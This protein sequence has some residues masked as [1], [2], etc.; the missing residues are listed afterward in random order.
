MFNKKYK[1]GMKDAAKA[2]EAFGEKQEK[3]L[4]VILEELRSGNI[5]IKTAIDNLDGNINSLYEY[6]NSQELAKLYTVYTPFDIK[7]LKDNEKLFLGGA[8]LKLTMDRTPTDAQQ[9]YLNAVLKYLSLKEPPFGVDLFAIENI[10]EINAQKAIYQTVLEYLILQDGNHY[11]ETEVQQEFLDSFCLNLRSR[12]TI[13]KHVEILYSSTGSTGLSEKYNVAD[14]EIAIK[15]RVA[16]EREKLLNT[17]KKLDNINLQLVLECIYE[18]YDEDLDVTCGEYSSKSSC[19]K[20][21]EGELRKKHNSI[22]EAFNTFSSNS[23]DKKALEE[24]KEEVEPIFEEIRHHSQNLQNIIKDDSF[25]EIIDL[26]KFEFYQESIQ[27]A[28]KRNL[29]DR[30]CSI[31]SFEYYSKMLEYES[32]DFGDGFWSSSSWDCTNFFEVDIYEDAQTSADV[33]AKYANSIVREKVSS[34]IKNKIEEIIVKVF[35]DI[36]LHKPQRVKVK[37]TSIRK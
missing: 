15:E 31:P 17:V 6:L 1:K 32:D 23:L 10:E 35:P 37:T 24:I 30:L 34:K 5:D 22:C 26:L 21:F 2:Y 28:L 14:P 16:E 36:D 7:H 4:E 9:I 3:A 20:A 18:L 11:D 8:L 25:S 27:E 33:F 29:S 19:Q 12:E 13:A